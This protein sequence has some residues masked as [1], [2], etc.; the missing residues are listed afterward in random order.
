MGE[1]YRELG[2]RIKKLREQRGMSQQRLA[3]LFGFSRPTITQIE[4]GE[5]KI[6]ADE[7]IKLVQIF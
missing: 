2:S 6:S 3:E 7:L 5:R 4:M 1:V